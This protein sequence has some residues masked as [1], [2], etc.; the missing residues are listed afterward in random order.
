MVDW[1]DSTNLGPNKGAQM[2]RDSLKIVVVNHYIS[3]ANSKT[4]H[5]H[6]F[7]ILLMLDIPQTN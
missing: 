3:F 2:A 5:S 1:K 7:P 6:P 4:R